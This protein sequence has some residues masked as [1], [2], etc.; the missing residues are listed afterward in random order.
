MFE[1]IVKCA[2]KQVF[3]PASEQDC[4]AWMS[5]N[6]PIDNFNSDGSLNLGA[7]EI[8][9][10]LARTSRGRRFLPPNDQ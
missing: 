9:P 6:C 3:G 4:Q 2:G 1:Y 8:A 5:Q 10:V 7:Y